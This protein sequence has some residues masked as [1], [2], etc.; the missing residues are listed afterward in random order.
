MYLNDWVILGVM[1]DIPAPWSIWVWKI[2]F[3][4]YSTVNHQTRSAMVSTAML[5]YQRVF[6]YPLSFHCTGWLRAG[7]KNMEINGDNPQI[8]PITVFYD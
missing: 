4:R 2:A 5:N 8:S 6:N 3:N 1:V 7:K